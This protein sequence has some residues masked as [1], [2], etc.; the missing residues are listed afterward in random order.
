MAALTGLLQSYDDRDQMIDGS[1]CWKRKA[2][3]A[4]NIASAMME[5]RQK[6]MPQGIEGRDY[7]TYGANTIPG[8]DGQRIDPSLPEDAAI[9]M[10]QQGQD[11]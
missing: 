3:A 2:S 9:D 4:Y 5:E 8:T 7:V 6:H 1:S 11:D 10:K